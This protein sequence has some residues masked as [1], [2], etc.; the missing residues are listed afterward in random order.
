MVLQTEHDSVVGPDPLE[1][2]VAVEETVI[3][4]GDLGVVLPVQRAVHV[5]LHENLPVSAA[6]WAIVRK[7]ACSFVSRV[8]SGWNVIARTRPSRTRTGSPR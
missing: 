1:H 6:G 2:T 7:Y 8:S 3:E 5:D 4:H